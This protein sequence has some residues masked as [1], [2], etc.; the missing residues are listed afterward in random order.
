M[1][2]NAHMDK[3]TTSQVRHILDISNNTA[4]GLMKQHGQLTDETP[5]G[6]YYI[7][8]RIVREWITE[9]IALAYGKEARFNEVTG[10]TP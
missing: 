9:E 8:A 7:D 2:Y 1:H 6:K 3:L 10:G 5:R 4:L